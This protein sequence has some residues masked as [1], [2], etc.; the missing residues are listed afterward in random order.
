MI[1]LTGKSTSVCHVINRIIKP[2]F[3]SLL[4]RLEGSTRGLDAQKAARETN[5]SSRRKIE[6]ESQHVGQ[7]KLG[8]LVGFESGRV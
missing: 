5:L 1:L 7:E 4:A 3:T 6:I 8:G 2:P